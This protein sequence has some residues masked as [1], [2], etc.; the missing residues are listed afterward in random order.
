[1]QGLS[2]H[3]I[4]EAG[5]KAMMEEADKMMSNPAVRKAYEDFML[6]VKLTQAK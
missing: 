6:L 3:D 1:L 4:A 2:T 5:V